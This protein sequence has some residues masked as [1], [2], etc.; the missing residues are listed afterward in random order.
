[1]TP[2]L[3]F[4]STDDP[5]HAD[6]ALRLRS[7][8]ASRYGQALD[9]NIDLIR[10]GGRSGR[11]RRIMRARSADGQA[12]ALKSHDSR[13]RNRTE[14]HAL[15][16]L[17]DATSDS[18][19]PIYL[20][21]DCKYYTMEWVDGPLMSQSLGRADH[22]QRIAQTGTWLAR[23]HTH[24][25]PRPLFE[26]HLPNL[27]L[28]W[29]P[30][31]DA[32]GQ[33]SARLK[34]QL[35]MVSM[36]SGPRAVLHGDFH[37]GNLFVLPDR[38]MVFDREE[39]CFGLTF[40]DVARFLVD[41]AQRRRDAGIEGLTWDGNDD[42][43]RRMFFD[44]YGPIKSRDLALYDTVED[45]LAFRSWRRQMRKGRDDQTA[46]MQARGLLGDAS[47]LSRP[48]RLVA[49]PDGSVVWT[50]ASAAQVMG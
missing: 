18:I 36:S 26:T 19:L 16:K 7:W 33:A 5:L 25:F 22:G 6:I 11:T 34:Q 45:A 8:L 24:R 9:W 38:V 27:R 46:D 13:L 41:L 3:T 21:K 47:P 43:D 44:A 2:S 49:K 10:T 50:Q 15:R 48:A 42:T 20:A 40:L 12:I 29:R 14:F 17:H 31:T 28:P 4:A 32:V 35:R 37:A 39:D 1:M 30:G 23:L